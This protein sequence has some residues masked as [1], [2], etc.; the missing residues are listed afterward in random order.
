[1]LGVFLMKAVTVMLISPIAVS[2]VDEAV[3]MEK[4]PKKSLVL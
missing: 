4:W 1:M 2:F 3:V